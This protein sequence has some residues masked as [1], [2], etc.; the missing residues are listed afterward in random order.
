MQADP[1]SRS[2]LF[3]VAA[4]GMASL[5]AQVVLLREVLAS[6]HGNELVLGVVLAGWLSLTGLASAFG[7]RWRARPEAARRSLAVVLQSAPALLLAS[8]W[9]VRYTEPSTLGQDQSLPVVVAAAL[10]ALVPAS[11]LGGLCF[12]WAVAAADG[13]RQVSSVYVAETLGMAAAGL[14]FHFVLARSV[15]SAWGL[16]GAGALCAVAGWGLKSW[17][18]PGRWRLLVGVAV[19]AGTGLCVGSVTASLQSARY[20]GVAVLASQ[21]SRHGLLAVLDRNG[22]HIFV[23][24]GVLLFT[25]EDTAA[26]EERIHLPLLLH[27]SPQRILMVGGGLGGGLA[28][29]LEHDPVAI[30]YAEMDPEILALARTFADARTRAA[31]S[32]ARVHTMGQDARRVLRESSRRYDIIL[33]DLP[34]PQNALQAR[35]STDRRWPRGASWRW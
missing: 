21:P 8:L 13:S 9:L 19:V 22:Q 31:L 12:A 26:A 6:S 30:D 5:L 27:P 32:D 10:I 2:I 15:G 20:P 3:A 7:G 29:A 35:L 18:A 4:A 34:I 11:T 16:W 33:I 1:R 24:D 14:V 28:Q 17:G 25:S 23:H